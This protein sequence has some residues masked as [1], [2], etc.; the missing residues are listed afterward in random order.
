MSHRFERRS[1]RATRWTIALTA[2]FMLASL[3]PFTA[4]PVAAAPPTAGAVASGFLFYKYQ[5]PQP[6][7]DG[8]GLIVSEGPFYTPGGLRVRGLRGVRGANRR[9]TSRLPS[10]DPTGPRSPPSTPR[11]TRSTR[12][13]RSGS[14]RRPAGLPGGSRRSISVDGEEAGRTTFGHKLLGAEITLDSAGA[15]R[16]GRRPRGVRFDRRDG[17]RERPGRCEPDGRRSPLLARRDHARR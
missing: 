8:L 11:T 12:T 13:G 16:S 5:T 3:L 6:L 2:S 10:R 9:R 14:R 17:Q 15:E 1:A 4:S 7:C